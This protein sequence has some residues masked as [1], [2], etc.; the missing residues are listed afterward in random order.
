VE[1]DGATHEIAPGELTL[2]RSV[3]CNVVAD[4]SAVSKVHARIERSSDQLLLEDLGSS[5]GTFVNGSRVRTAVLRHGDTLELAKVVRF[6]VVVEQGD[7]RTSGTY[8]AVMPPKEGEP[9]FSGDWKTRYEWDSGEMAAFA[10][11]AA[12][13]RPDEGERQTADG[14]VVK[15]STPAAPKPAAAAPAAA[16]AAKP[17][18][19]PAAPASPAPVATPA[20]AKPEAP[21]S[22]TAARP[23]VAATPSGAA[24]IPPRA[25]ASKPSLQEVAAARSA[26]PATPAAPAPAPPA[27]PK[28]PPAD[29]PINATVADMPALATAAAAAAATGPIAVARFTADKFSFAVDKP[30]RY[31]VGR[32]TSTAFRVDH[33]TVSRRHAAVT[34]GE[35]RLTL[36][37]ED[38]GAANGTRL[39]GREIKG[40]EALKDGDVLQLG[41]VSFKVALQRS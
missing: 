4:V 19:A 2:G 14:T 20:A 26:V 41:E 29:E 35:D 5:N 13:V 40:S 36:V 3:A 21:A 6:N 12:G 34:L 39:N 23:A 22:P 31:E 38:L 16:P 15:K 30:G 9:R 37:A 33:T 11:V 17:T 8:R 7:V 18:A 24:A 27:P 32:A 1:P 25:A 10:A 28:A